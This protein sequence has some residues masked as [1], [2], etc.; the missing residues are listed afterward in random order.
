M[1]PLGT[2]YAPRKFT[3]KAEDMVAFLE[4]Y[5]HLLHQYNVTN[6]RDRCYTILQYCSTQV[7]QY[8]KGLREYADYDWRALKKNLL[9]FYDAEKGEH[10][11]N[12]CDV[13]EFAQKS[14]EK[15]ITNL[16]LWKKYYRRHIHEVFYFWMGVHKDLCTPLEACIQMKRQL[17]GEDSE[18]EESEDD[19]EAY[20]VKEICA[21]AHHHFCRNRFRPG[22]ESS[23]S[24]TDS[25]EDDT[26]DD[27]NA[28]KLKKKLKLEK[29]H[30]ELRKEK[31][32]EKRQME[33]TSKM[34]GSP[35]DLTQL[36]KQLNH[37]KPDH[38]MYAPMYLKAVMMD[39]TGRVRTEGSSHLAQLH[40]RAPRAARHAPCHLIWNTLLVAS[41]WRR[42][43]TR[44]H[45]ARI[46]LGSETR[47]IK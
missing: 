20:S 13:V 17:H 21:A 45:K 9:F 34:S 28:E 37:M 41:P 23:G 16:G 10:T 47:R 11:Y 7:K 42:G 39:T 29:Q 33:R 5:K 8:I 36:V 4:H 24:K 30:K 43:P 18:S 15:L 44:F 40:S 12:A 22:K 19:E 26:S 2:R 38:E 6:G 3:G 27:S 31:R 1:P 35:A 25:D 32:K 14:C 46:V